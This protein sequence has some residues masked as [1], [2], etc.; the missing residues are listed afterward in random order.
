MGY[1]V[2][3]E[4]DRVC[5][6]VSRVCVMCVCVCVIVCVGLGGGWYGQNR[7]CLY[8]RSKDVE[9]RMEIFSLEVVNLCMPAD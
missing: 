1:G 7:L 8:E 4:G 3:V 2:G 6:C 9:E 5:V